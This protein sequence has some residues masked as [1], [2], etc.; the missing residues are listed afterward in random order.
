M[1]TKSDQYQALLK[2]L[3][4][5]PGL[6]KQNN[7]T[8]TASLYHFHPT[9]HIIKRQPNNYWTVSPIILEWNVGDWIY[10]KGAENKTMSLKKKQKEKKIKGIQARCSKET[11]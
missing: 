8:I 5:V 2:T 9:D 10:N 6:N 11:C 3:S 1:G 4:R 7:F